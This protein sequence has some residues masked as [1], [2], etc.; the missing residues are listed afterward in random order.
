MRIVSACRQAKRAWSILR[1]G[2]VSQQNIP[3]QGGWRAPYRPRASLCTAL[4]PG[5]HARHTSTLHAHANMHVC[6]YRACLQD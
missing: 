2:G 3:S 4:L 1:A 6:T 5:V